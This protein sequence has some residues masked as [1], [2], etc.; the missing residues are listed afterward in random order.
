MAA[1][2]RNENIVDQVISIARSYGIAKVGFT[3]LD[4][5]PVHGEVLVQGQGMMHA[6]SLVWEI[7]PPAA[8]ER[9]EVDGFYDRMVEGR[10]IMDE[11]ANAIAKQLRELAYRALSITS[12]FT[13]DRETILGQI[14]HKAVAH[15]AGMG[16]IGRSQLLV[17][18]EY[19][20][21]VR[22]CTVLTDAELD[23]GA[24]PM[25]NRCGTCRSCIDGCPLNALKFKEF[26]DH[27][28]DRAAV[29][30]H[31]TCH[32]QEEAWLKSSPPKF[33]ARCVSNCPWGKPSPGND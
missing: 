19:G 4:E 18:P 15:Q 17:T 5:I 28:K 16:W 23:H 21:R 12:V 27:T 20:P 30:D 13:M 11:A 25:K 33:C 3:P 29:F 14:S 6:I 9:S 10:S 1:S 8:Y 7:P 24:K 31:L 32:R 26:D 2:E 22:L